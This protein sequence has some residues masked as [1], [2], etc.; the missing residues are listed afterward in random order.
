MGSA[1]ESSEVVAEEGVIPT[2]LL[3]HLRH[4]TRLPSPRGAPLQ[5]HSLRPQPVH[6]RQSYSDVHILGRVRDN[7]L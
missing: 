5:A 1:D 7:A 4:H 2:Y 6:H 3:L